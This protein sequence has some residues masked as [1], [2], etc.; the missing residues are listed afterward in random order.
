MFPF[1]PVPGEDCAKLPD[2]TVDVVFYVEPTTGYIHKV[3][4]RS[5]QKGNTPGKIRI[6]IGGAGAIEE[7]EEEEDEVKE[8]DDQ[9]RRIYKRGLP[10]RKLGDDVSKMDYDVTFT[11]HA[12]PVPL[13]IDATARKL[14]RLDSK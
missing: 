9:G 1:G 11:K 10:V 4:T 2:L 7:E 3:K 6:Q 8:K 5:Y 13:K 14:L 12:H